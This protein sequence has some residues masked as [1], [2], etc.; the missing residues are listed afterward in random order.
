MLNIKSLCLFLFSTSSAQ[1]NPPSQSRPVYVAL[2]QHSI[3][4]LENKLRDVS[5]PTS[6]HYGNYLSSR[7]ISEMISPTFDEK[8]GITEWIHSYPVSQFSDDGDSLR[9]T[10]S[11]SVLSDMFHWTKEGHKS[12]SVP[13]AYRELVDFVEMYSD[14]KP[15]FNSNR[16]YPKLNLKTRNVSVD[17]R[18][19]GRESL[20]NIYNVSDVDLSS[21][22]HL[23]LSGTVEYQDNPGFTNDDLNQQ[24]Q[25]NGQK[26]LN[27]T[28]I[29]GANSDIDPE[30]ELDVQMISQ[31]ANGVNIS[32]WD[33]PY[34]LYSF[35][36]DLFNN[37]TI[38]NVVSMSWG[39]AEDSQCDI[40]QC[41]NM[42]SQDYVNRVNV[43][44]MKLALRGTTITVSSGD[45]G[46]PG[47]TSETCN[48]TR[49]MNPVFPGSSPYVLS[50]GATFV[51]DDG[52]HS[53]FKSPIC[54]NNSCISG[55]R[56]NVVSFDTIGWT[57]GGGFEAYGN[58]IPYWQEKALHSYLRENQH[59]LNM[60][61][62]NNQSRAY[63]DIVAVGH[64]CPTVLAGS[65]N[66]V[67]GTSCSSPII[68]GV[69]SIINYYRALN[70][71]PS[72][73]FV[74]PLLYH[75]YDTCH[76]CFQDIRRGYNWCT[77][78]VCCQPGPNFGFR[79][80]KGFD[81]ASGMGSP[82]VG[83]ILEALELI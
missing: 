56:E 58:Q 24:Q 13:E 40:V 51:Q 29:H 79:A 76:E 33:S 10:V 72:V 6:K 22:S 60:S 57:S 52:Q 30:S 18:N 28:D 8:Q 47:R 75:L 38:P 43:E 73:G 17:S 41:T 36:V 7:E 23:T 25:L 81:P 5:D 50:V 69:V 2:K 4:L 19:F 3:D 21:H 20:Q 37:E 49:P 26:L 16:K 14:L 45:A 48:D 80:V 44:Y 31:T 15:I 59:H 27:I 39:W 78:E 77:E 53:S 66:M 32:F 70:N 74:N 9:F 82:N 54:Q 1:S 83:K 12:Y 61:R 63:P 11:E 46:A 42:T 34:W 62:F 71:Q 64:N 55:K 67:D 68:T 35:A 65:L